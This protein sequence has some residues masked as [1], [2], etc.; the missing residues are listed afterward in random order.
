MIALAAAIRN[1]W[2]AVERDLATLQLDADDIGTAKLPV[3]KFISIVLAAP[4]G[5][6]CHHFNPNAWS[7]IEELIATLGEQQAG[8]VNLSARYERPEVDTTPQKPYSPMDNMP[9]YRGIQLEAYPADEFT[10]KLKERQ[11]KAR[12]EAS[13]S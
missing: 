7:R 1:H 11:R 12:E 9:D 5:S 2:H 13:T 10:V 4:P 8:I 3:T 6:A